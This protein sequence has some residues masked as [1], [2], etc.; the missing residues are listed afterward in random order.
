[1][2]IQERAAPIPGAGMEGREMPFSCVRRTAGRVLPESGVLTHRPRRQCR[3]NTRGWRAALRQRLFKQDQQSRPG[4]LGL[5]LV[6]NLGIQRAPAMQGT[7]I[8]LDLAR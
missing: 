1:M 4:L 3:P 8:D 6:V 2:N 7:L 5:L